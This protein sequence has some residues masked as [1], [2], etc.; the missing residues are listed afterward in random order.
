VSVPMSVPISVPVQVDRSG[1]DPNGGEDG[2][3]TVQTSPELTA[4]EQMAT[5]T[6]DSRDGGGSSGSDGGSS[7]SDGG[8]SGSD[9][10]SGGSD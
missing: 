4:P 5:T 6:T 10:G 7:G 3:T 9:A 8:S 1:A 2:S